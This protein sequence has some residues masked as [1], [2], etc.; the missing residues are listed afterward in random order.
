MGKTDSKTMT[1]HRSAKTGRFVTQ[2]YADTHPSTTVTERRQ[3]K[4]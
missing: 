1:L 4:G 3:K 2:R